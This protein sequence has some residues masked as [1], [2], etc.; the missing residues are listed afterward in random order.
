MSTTQPLAVS[1]A[2]TESYQRDGVVCIRG[3]FR[4]HW[5]DL[6]AA[7]IERN[8]I[9]PGPFF[10][11]QTRPGD[12][13][14]YMFDYW[15]WPDTPEIRRLIFD[16]P[17]ATIAARLLGCP[18]VRLLMDNWFA[19]EAGATNAA[20]WHQDEPYFDYSGR[21]CNLLIAL[22]SAPAAESLS[23]ARGSHRRGLFKAMNF[24]DHVPFEG[25]GSDYADTPFDDATAAPDGLLNWNLEPGDVLAFDLRTLHR[26]PLDRR[27]SSGAR[28]RR[29]SLRF[30]TPE[31]VFK[32]RGPWTAEISD[33]LLA[34]GQQPDA[35]LD[36]PLCPLLR[37]SPNNTA[38]TSGTALHRPASGPQLQ[39]GRP[40]PAFDRAV[41]A[42]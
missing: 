21:M 34:L 10:R 1:Q 5:L 8:R 4:G 27:P 31:T 13:A 3:A 15:T 36:N 9:S 32:P 33:H 35:P 17:A 19:N 24:R 12:P 39:S 2:V 18:Q 29:L 41:A 40:S 42:W 28:R 23:F 30:G 14:R 6:A 25:Q 16:S 38:A 20:P 22:D 7:G 26:G 11:D 37:P